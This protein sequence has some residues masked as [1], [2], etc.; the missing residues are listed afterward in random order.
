LHLVTREDADVVTPHL[1]GN[2]TEHGVA[3]LEL[4]PEHCVREGLDDGAFQ[5]DCIFFRLCDDELS[6]LVNSRSLIVVAVDLP[7]AG[8]TNSQA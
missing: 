8:Q 2:V 3:I 4:D 5:H 7:R 1:S 6:S